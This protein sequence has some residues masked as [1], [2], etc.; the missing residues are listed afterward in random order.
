MIPSFTDSMTRN[1]DAIPLIQN[2]RKDN[3]AVKKASA[4]LN[5][6][7][8]LIVHGKLGS[9]VSKTGET[10]IQRYA[11]QNI[12]WDSHC[13]NSL[14]ELEAALSE[15]KII[16]VNGGFGIWNA[17]PYD[18]NKVRDILEKVFQK[19]QSVGHC[20]LVLGI[21]TDLF[22]KYRTI[23]KDHNML[24]ELINL[25]SLIPGERAELKEHL[26][27]T[28]KRKICDKADCDCKKLDFL[29]VE[30]NYDDIATRL[31]IES[32]GLHHDL[33]GPFL[34]SGDML[35]V[36]V[37]HFDEMKVENTRLYGCLMYI[38][39]KGKYREGDSTDIDSSITDALQLEV[40]Q[41]CFEE[42]K[43]L[44]LKYT[45]RTSNLD[46]VYVQDDTT[47]TDSFYYVFQHMFLY[48]CAFHSLFKYHAKEVMQFCNIDA[49]LQIVRPDTENDNVKFCITADNE[50][51]YHFYQHVIIKESGLEDLLEDHPLVKYVAGTRV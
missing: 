18:E 4:A 42:C 8:I 48:L 16:F 35:Q 2:T 5:K 33:I 15:K 29:H 27:N 41:T 34:H 46:R 40:S 26:E 21:R 36:I 28:L 43:S 12:G 19:M 37:S 3:K 24:K 38:V 10:V 25:D 23:F 22:E 11:S 47:R 51:I 9:G 32:L 44:L 6:Q 30:K 50:T 14:D 39:A 13:I 17:M 45:K 20:K 1:E 7:N 49:V 31:K